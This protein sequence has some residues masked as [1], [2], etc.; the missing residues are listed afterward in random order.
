MRHSILQISNSDDKLDNYI[1]SARPV[2]DLVPCVSLMNNFGYVTI[3]LT[4]S[5]PGLGRAPF[6]SSRQRE[7]FPKLLSSDPTWF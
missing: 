3:F 5:T 6:T 4:I 2:Y 7:Q 1:S